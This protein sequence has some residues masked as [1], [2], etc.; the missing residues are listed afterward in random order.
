MPRKTLFTLSERETLTAFPQEHHDLVRH[1]LFNDADLALI[2]QRRGKHNRLGFAIQLCY[3]RYPGKPIPPDEE[4]PAHLLSFVS[5][6]L[7]VP[8]THWKRYAIRK[9]TRREHLTELMNW[10]G[11]ASFTL[12]HFRLSVQ[13]LL[14]T[15]VQTE[16]GMV[17]AKTLLDYLRTQKVVIPGM[18]VLERICAEA[19]TLGTKRVYRALT[20]EL[21][22]GQKEQLDRLLLMRN[23]Q[24]QTF[25]NWLRQPHGFPN[26]KHVL[27]HIERIEY[28][29]ALSL[30]D[31]LEKMV[32]Q[33][34]LRK[35]ARE[36]GQMT[37]QH[38]RDF[39][40]LRRHA[41]LAAVVLDTRA[42]LIDELID[43]HDR[44][45]ASKEN[46]ARRKHAEQFQ[47]S[48]KQI[49]E[50]LKVLSQAGRLIQKARESKSDPFDAIET[51]IG[52]QVFLDSIKSA[53]Q[54]SQPEFD[55]LTLIIDAY[56][57]LRRY[58]PAFLDALELKAAPV[59]QSL[60]DAVNVLRKLNLTKA[61]KLPEDVPTDFIRKR[62]A[63]LVF[64][65][66]EIN[67]KYYE[68]C[69][70][71][72]LKNALRSGDIWV[73][74]SR[75]FMDFEDYLLPLDKYRALFSQQ[76]LGLDI[77]TDGEL[78]LEQK[79]NQLVTALKRVELH[80][81]DNNLP[82]TIVTASGMRI[83]PL[84]N[85]VPDEAEKL[86][87]KVSALMP[88][89]KITEL[90]LEVDR[91]TDFSRHFTHLKGGQ[92]A[93]DRVMLM[94]AVLA[95]GINLG[96]TKMASSCPGTSYAKLSWLQAWHVR[97]DTYSKALAE[98]TNAQHQHHFSQWWGDGTTSSSDGQRF[99]A[100]GRGES[101]GHFNAKYGSEP[102]SIFYTHISDHYAPFHTRI[103]NSPARD[104]TYVLDG[105]LNHESELNIEEHYTDTAGFT[106][107]VFALMPILG[108]KF[109]PRIRD[110]SDKRLYIAGNKSDYPTLGGLIGGDVNFDYIA[111]HWDDILR[112]SASIGKGVVTA[113]LMLRK[114][115]SYPRQNGLALALRELGRIER[116]LFTLEWM[117][118]INLR[119]RVQ[120][121]LNKGEAKNALS[122]AVFFNRL[123]ELRDRSFENQRYR[124]SGLN[125]VVAAII[126]WN[127]EYISQAL[128]TLRSR[129][130]IID[131]ALLSHLSPLG[132][133]HIN[134][135]GDYIWPELDN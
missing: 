24:S 133:E 59:S 7:G 30:P 9:T 28:I 68:L 95:D 92:P 90:L 50:Q 117:Q 86:I 61:R 130:E 103:I 81:A 120:A 54:L 67:K 55:H 132:W 2:N 97:D 119:R 17:L 118:D 48:G 109:A 26:A 122:R 1:Y 77:E 32:H 134:L 105:L 51:S 11:M 113:S 124:A 23:Q 27:K 64:T 74:H 33:N 43:M 49:N 108:F 8:I 110:L 37:P 25:I 18:E 10:L 112:L 47:S 114:L 31:G 35:I 88:K 100:G 62:W 44:I 22:E 21:S 34:R 41:T 104:A 46:V 106:D 70:L 121:G 94:T 107:H 72:E 14:K 116:T 98:L 66:E 129:G 40:P 93:S 79:K 16:S 56:P 29:Q 5:E 60:L 53:E 85:S 82:G 45:M 71:S 101:K 38:L 19:I 102:G 83:T 123:G 111:L 52:W 127:T 135:T 57:Q 75:Q 76:E 128:E 126:L 96:L 80:A 63:S 87:R 131:D 13:Y 65:E 84:T 3:L 58:T 89:V 36:G 15:S 20:S 42:T 6:Q 73:R 69:V 4:P 99:N 39:E 91:W 115:G 78:F 12:S 125:L